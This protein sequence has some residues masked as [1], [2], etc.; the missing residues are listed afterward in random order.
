MTYA[1]TVLIVVTSH[2][3][4]GST[5][6]PTGFYFEEMA[7]PYWAFRD[8]GYAV[9]IASVQGG[10]PPHDPASLKK[11]GANPASVKR[12]LNDFQSMATLENTRS[13]DG[14]SAHDYLGIFLPG[15][16]GTV[17]DFP[18]SLSLT[19]LVSDVFNQGK[20]VGAVCHGP[21]GLI[22]A[23]RP[24]G[25]SILHDRTVNSFTDEE[26]RAVEL[27]NE[28]PFLLESRIRELGG[29]FQCSSNFQAHAVRDQNLIT[30]QNPASSDLVAEL[31][32][33][34]LNEISQKSIT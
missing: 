6:N 19:R 32:V 2:S 13:V 28:V 7:T 20:V 31:M 18:N 21:T 30:G 33:E 9:E 29:K 4:L 11:E 10:N 34:A 8:A 24:D 12:F 15:G 27:E 3:D 25:K 26:E 17:W 5:G 22:N 23:T 16:H 14:L 1:K